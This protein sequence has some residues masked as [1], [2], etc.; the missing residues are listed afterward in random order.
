M[1]KVRQF[2][3]FKFKA[4]IYIQIDGTINPSRNV[5][6]KT[7]YV[8]MCVCVRERERERERERD[9]KYQHQIAQNLYNH[10]TYQLS[11]KL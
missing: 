7:I 8:Y 10:K 6:C 2:S 5:I 9:L 11:Q 3:Y 4:T 1:E